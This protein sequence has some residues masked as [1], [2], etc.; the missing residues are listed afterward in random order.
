MRPRGSPGYAYACMKTYAYV[1][2]YVLRNRPRGTSKMISVLSGSVTLAAPA[3][4][5]T[6]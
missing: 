5:Y 4:A 3:Y 1:Y 2:V 6:M